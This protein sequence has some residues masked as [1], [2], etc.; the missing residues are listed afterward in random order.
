MLLVK[1]RTPH[2]MRQGVKSMR[3]TLKSVFGVSLV[4]F[5]LT[6]VASGSASAATWSIQEPAVQ[7]YAQGGGFTGVSCVSSESCQAVGHYLTIPILGSEELPLA[8]GSSGATWTTRPFEGAKSRPAGI[9]CTTIACVAVGAI[10]EGKAIAKPLSAR[11]NAEGWQLVSVPLPTGAQGGALTGVS[12]VSAVCTAVGY[13]FNNAGTELPLAET[14]NTFTWSSQAPPV[15]TGAKTASLASISCVSSE[16]CQAVG[17]Y[18]N[19]SGK[20][21]PLTEHWNGKVWA[22]QPSSSEVSFRLTSVACAFT[23]SCF[24]TGATL[25]PILEAVVGEHWN[26]EKWTI[27]ELPLPAGGESKG[28]AGVSCG[29]PIAALCV[30]VG[31]YTRA[32]TE[33]PMAETLSGST[34][35]FSELPIA[36]GA[37]ST[38]PVSVSCTSAACDATGGYINKEGAET[39][40]IERYE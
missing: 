13:Y 39:P 30:E 3:I 2:R 23:G 4:V 29:G 8:E 37:K 7:K 16:W 11:R 22:I 19:S 36:S 38:L 40:L 31:S 9:S 35:S 12:C 1:E 34:W 32:G 18:I 20:E 27:M 15:P 24:A 25:T 26:G 28:L 14:G 5:A 21:L 10:R 17:V 6:A 33:M